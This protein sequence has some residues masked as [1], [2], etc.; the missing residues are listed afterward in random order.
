MFWKNWPYWLKGGTTGGAIFAIYL[1]LVLGYEKIFLCE[2]PVT[3]GIFTAVLNLPS[4][5]IANFIGR[6]QTAVVALINFAIGFLIGA[7]ISLI[8]RKIKNKK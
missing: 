1:F 6:P 8:Y 5:A 4:V 7:I 2:S 3:C